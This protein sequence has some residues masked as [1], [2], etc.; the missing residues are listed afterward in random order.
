M[1]IPSLGITR[2]FY[3]KLIFLPPE[4][5]QTPKIESLTK[6]TLLIRFHENQ[7][8]YLTQN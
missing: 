3:E 7:L 2:S 6:R 5:D 4:E 8:L 1:V